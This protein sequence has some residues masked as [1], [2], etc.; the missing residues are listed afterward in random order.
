[1][2][3]GFL[4]ILASVSRQP[5]TPTELSNGPFRGSHAI[6]AGSITKAMLTC[7]AWLRLSPDVYVRRDVEL[8]HRGRCAAAML[9]LPARTAIG[10]LSAAFLWGAAEAPPSVTVVAPRTRRLPHKDGLTVHY[11]TLADP[12]TTERNGLRLTTPERTVFDLGRRIDRVEALVVIDAMLHRH[13]LNP[14]TLQTMLL[15]RGAWPRTPGL[16]RLLRFADPRS[17]SPMETRLRL[18]LADAG[19]P[20]SATQFEVFD[21][22]GA[23]LGRLDLAWPE[24]RL[25]VEYD[26]DHH[27]Y[28]QQFRRDLDRCNRLRAA[29]W[30]VLRFTA[31]DVLRSPATTAG[32]VLT[33]LTTASRT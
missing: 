25:G 17:E 24:I 12:D 22:A 28:R 16:T 19:I 3:A 14:V 2:T 27:R 33:T 1:V 29:G 7:R 11:T 4:A 5:R 32:L 30:T 26:G 10:G 13:L 31:D 6:V 15:E 9:A 20:P 21:A 8:D 23:F 18:L